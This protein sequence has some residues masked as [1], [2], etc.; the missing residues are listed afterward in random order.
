MDALKRAEK[1]RQAQAEKQ[2]EGKSTSKS[3]L[4]LDPIDV[5]APGAEAATERPSEP[6]P[7]SPDPG[8]R[9]EEPGPPP[10]EPA[11]SPR[12]DP[13]TT[14]FSLSD[15]FPATEKVPPPEP[16]EGRGEE[17]KL[18]PFSLVRDNELSLEDTGEMLPVVREAEKS[19]ND[20]FDEPD[21]SAASSRGPAD[22]VGDD[23][24]TVLGGRGARESDTHARRAAQ[25]VFKAKA[26]AVARYQRN[27]TLVIALPLLFLGVIGIGLLL[28]WDQLER[29]FFGAPP[30]LVQ[31]LPQETELA[32]P[33]ESAAAVEA[34]R[35]AAA[36]GAASLG[37][38]AARKEPV[39][40]SAQP[41]RAVSGSVPPTAE[42]APMS[43]SESPNA[44][45]PV[46]GAGVTASTAGN[47]EAL[48][49]KRTP[50]TSPIP[51]PAVTRPPVAAVGRPFAGAAESGI[52]IS[53][54]TDPDKVHAGINE[55]YLAFQRG[56]DATAG[57]LYA[58]VNRQ[59]PKNRNALLGL[60]AI[61]VRGGNY[62]EAV[63]YYARLLSVNP[64]DPIARA[65]IIN[66]NQRVPAGEGESHVKR[67]LA[68]DPEQPFLY[69]TLG[70][71]Y[72]RQ[73]RWLEAQQAYFD[74]YRM[75]SDSADF[76]FNLAVSLDRIGQPATALTYYHRALE[77]AASGVASF[78]RR[79]VQLRINR[80]RGGG[81]G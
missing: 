34:S 48:A 81:Q 16:A 25:S 80:L 52:R 44:A 51:R 29:T 50:D 39:A 35:R 71:L 75:N 20:Y 33:P 54:R 3:T 42:G 64:R 79:A 8:P 23:D 22:T 70:N 56:D 37:Q 55:A 77:L 53:R 6:P 74:A 41:T 17:E 61:A 45:G 1:A 31:R 24:S 57:A 14:H 28:F 78:E 7:A 38:P 72:A 73:G 49:A 2:A 43:G 30:R 21:S 59:H 66:L 67:L 4:T 10:T 47:F 18:G 5:E 40:K 12:P 60:G 11:S 46:A 62:A 68:E 58:E 26:P 76:A 36:A 65:A 69:F 9:S 15:E 19:L 27:R 63:G 13:S 32:P